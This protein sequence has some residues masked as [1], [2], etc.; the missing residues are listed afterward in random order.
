MRACKN[1]KMHTQIVVWKK[2]TNVILVLLR[3]IANV[4]FLS[5]SQLLLGQLKKLKN[6]RVS[7]SRLLTVFF[8]ASGDCNCKS[9]CWRYRVQRTLL[10][11]LRCSFRTTLIN[12][13]RVS[14]YLYFNTQI[15]FIIS[16]WLDLKSQGSLS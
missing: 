5:L 11:R 2:C 3:V 16:G 12:L 7:N 4:I 10:L 13:V 14:T 6:N 1:A 15:G 8:T 9:F